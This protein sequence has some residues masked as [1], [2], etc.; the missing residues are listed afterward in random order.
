M[1][2]KQIDAISPESLERSFRNLFDVFGPAINTNLLAL[3]SNLETKLRRD[4]YLV[5]KRSKRFA[6]QL[7]IYEWAINFRGIKKRDTTLYSRSNQRDHLLLIGSR[8]IAEAHPHATEPERRHFQ[9]PSLR[10][11]IISPLIQDSK[12]SA[13]LEQLSGNIIWPV[14]VLLLRSGKITQL[15]GLCIVLTA[16]SNRSPRR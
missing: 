12:P 1:L 8:T 11:C 7:F 2:I 16:V 4:H 14:T 6:H 10:F 9:I 15:E 5:T 3:W 13:T